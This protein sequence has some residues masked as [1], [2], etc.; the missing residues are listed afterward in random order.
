MKIVVCDQS[1]KRAEFPMPAM[2]PKLTEED[3]RGLSPEEIEIPPVERAVWLE[4]LIAGRVALET[5]TSNGS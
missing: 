2:G 5:Q 1:F 4:L 3:R